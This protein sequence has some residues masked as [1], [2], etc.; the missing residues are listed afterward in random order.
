MPNEPL[1][2]STEV[3][4]LIDK[5]PPVFCCDD[6]ASNDMS[7]EELKPVEIPPTILKLELEPSVEVPVDITI[8]PLLP[9]SLLPV[10]TCR[11]PLSTDDVAVVMLSFPL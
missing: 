2:A 3:P 1:A 10:F 5:A 7:D 6:P 9:P 4:D 11:L 8:E